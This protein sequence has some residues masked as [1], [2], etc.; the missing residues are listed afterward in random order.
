MPRFL[1]TRYSR[2]NPT[3]RVS[4]MAFTH[5]S[6][7]H[8]PSKIQRFEG[9]QDRGRPRTWLCYT[10]VLNAR[11]PVT[12]FNR[13]R[14]KRPRIERG[15]SFFLIGQIN[16]V[17][18]VVVLVSSPERRQLAQR[19]QHHQSKLDFIK[20]KEVDVNCRQRMP[21]SAV[22]CLV[23]MLRMMTNDVWLSCSSPCTIHLEFAGACG[24]EAAAPA[25]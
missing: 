6:C 13:K 9:R 14:D 11:S 23:V 5:T 25:L 24:L 2:A 21:L 22:V 4:H 12:T 19:R 1:K 17:G 3:G 10:R 18:D 15:G 20:V 8:G 7:L 16:A